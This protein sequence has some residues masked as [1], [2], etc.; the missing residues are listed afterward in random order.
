MLY[1][2]PFAAPRGDNDLIDLLQGED[3]RWDGAAVMNVAGV[4]QPAVD[5]PVMAELDANIPGPAV[6]G[7]VISHIGKCIFIKK[8]LEV[9]KA[10][11][12]I[13]LLVTNHLTYKGGCP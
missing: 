2:L 10:S 6:M 11:Y 8:T 5:I 12:F 9:S 7:V 13:K 4:I 3:A 1:V